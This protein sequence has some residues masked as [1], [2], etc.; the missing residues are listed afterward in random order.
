MRKKNYDAFAPDSYYHVYSH[1]NGIENLFRCPDNYRYFLL[2]YAQHIRPVAETIAYCLM[3]NHM[4]FLVKI[5]SEETLRAAH[6]KKYPYKVLPSEPDWATFTM[7]Y[8][9]NWLTAYTKAYNK[10][11]RRRG[12]LFL[13]FTKRKH[14][15]DDAYFQRLIVYIHRNPIHHGFVRH[16]T[17]WRYTS[18]QAILSDQPTQVSRQAVLDWFGGREEFIRHHHRAQTS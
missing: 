12:A 17:D 1:A 10:Y 18:Y 2:K 5:R 14:V 4:H 8:F 3:P 15:A 9:K 16:L 11:Y 6:A 13:K 7:Q